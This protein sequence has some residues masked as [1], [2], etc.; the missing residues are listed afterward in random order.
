MCA[1]VRAEPIV[2]WFNRAKSLTGFLSDEPLTLPYFRSGALRRW[3][4]NVVRDEHISRAFVFSSPMAQYVLGLPR[5]RCFV[6]F[7]DMDSAK[8]GEYAARR[9]WPASAVY[10]R[11]ARRLLAY[12]RNVAGQVDFSIF[13]TDLEAQT[14]RAKGAGVGRVVAVGNGVDTDYYAP[15][16]D[17]KSPFAAGE[18]PIVFTGAMD[19]WPNIDAVTWFAS[20]VLPE[21]VRRDP[22]ARFYVVGMN[23]TAAV[24][25]LASLSGTTVTGRVDDVRPYLQH[26]SV[27]VAPLRVARGIQNKVLEAMAMAKSV[28]IT[29]ATASALSAREDIE[30]EVASDAH[31]F[32]GKVLELLDP[33]RANAMGELA[34][35]RVLEDYAW[36]ASF[37]LLD[38]IMQR[39]SSDSE[40]VVPIAG[41][42]SASHC[43]ES[44]LR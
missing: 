17:F 4:K 36:S 8:W 16:P 42:H 13:V 7:V 25:S 38:D 15:S 27:V 41:R 12:E 20:E 19:Y 39:G 37:E 23:P 29:A 31:D 34:R 28:V 33:A 18:R 5:L 14:F 24:R 6:D 35:S 22:S 1:D 43:S 11:E 9:A 32:A 3:I 21:V 44:D 40:S 2:P 30:I 10:G 26:A